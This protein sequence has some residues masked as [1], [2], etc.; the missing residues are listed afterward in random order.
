MI[1]TYRAKNGVVLH[2]VKDERHILHKIK[3]RKLS[4]FNTYCV[5]TPSKHMLLKKIYRKDIRDAKTR[6][7]T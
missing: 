7:K 1:W 4:G 6:K 2:R 3:R 5:G